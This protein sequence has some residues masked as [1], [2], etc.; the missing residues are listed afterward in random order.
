MGQTPLFQVALDC[1][2][3]DEAFQIAKLVQEFVDILEIGNVLLKK[4][5]CRIIEHFKKAFPEKLV[6]VDTK[7]VDL[8]KLE[9]QVMFDAGA[10]IIS[11][12]GVA[13]DVTIGFAIQEAHG[14][15]KQVVIDLIGLGDSYRQVKRLSHLQPDYLT[16]HTGIDER[17]VENDLFEKIEIISQISPVPLA[18]SGGI[19]LDDIPYLL[20]FRPTIII[21]GSAIT[22]NSAPRETA[23]RFRETID[24][25]GFANPYYL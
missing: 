21:V 22:K 14:R 9:A 18:I 4:E 15:Q 5:G 6:F 2:H 24:T 10:D 11:V 25:P 17:S 19:E 8:G 3:F 20:V 7:T 23:Q 16:V 1:I 13:S 12:C